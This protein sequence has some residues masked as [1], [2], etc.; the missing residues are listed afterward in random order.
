MLRI[1][2]HPLLLV[3]LLTMVFTGNIALYS[4]ILCSLIIHE[5][6]HLLAAKAVG[7]QLKSCVIMPYGG[8]IKLQQEGT[9]LQK[10]II[11]FGG[12]C[13]TL[14]GMASCIWLPPLLAEP[15]LK[16]QFYLLCLNLLPFLPL[17]GGKIICYT[18]LTLFPRAKIY[19]VFLSLSLCFFT[20]IAVVAFILLP[21]SIPI[22]LLSILLWM[23]VLGEWKYRKYHIAYEKIVL[24][25]LT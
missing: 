1:T 21:K 15:F 13:A 22:L 17:D 20:I 9:Y 23:N 6:G 8:E 7:L 10:L 12:P 5:V 16:A 4:I 14:I 2:I 18:L 25:R 11:A 24:N 3:V 19:E